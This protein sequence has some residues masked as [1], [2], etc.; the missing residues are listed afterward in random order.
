MPIAWGCDS[1]T[2]NIFVS[3][4]SVMGSALIFNPDGSGT[5]EHDLPA[6]NNIDLQGNQTTQD[7]PLRYRPAH[8]VPFKVPLYDEGYSQIQQDVY[9]DLKEQHA[10]NPAELEKLEKPDPLYR[11]YYRPSCNLANTALMQKASSLIK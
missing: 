9:D 1:V 2:S 6:V 5:D 3:M 11:W 7:N 4:Q 10:D 8:Y